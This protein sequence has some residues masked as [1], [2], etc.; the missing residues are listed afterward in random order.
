MAL[1]KLLY[2]KVCIKSEDKQWSVKPKGL[3]INGLDS[4]G[5][6]IK[7]MLQEQMS[8]IEGIRRSLTNKR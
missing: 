1:S 3:D 2:Q 5:Q 7:E 4:S 6:K 8:D